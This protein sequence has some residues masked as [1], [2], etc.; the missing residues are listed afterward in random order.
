MSSLYEVKV[1]DL[2]NVADIDIIDVLIKPGDHVTLEQTLAVMET[3]KAT[4]DLPSSAAG[5]VQQVHIK[6]GD[7]VAEG[8]LIVTL[9]VNDQPET[10]NPSVALPAAAAAPASVPPLLMEEAAP[11]AGAK[12]PPPLE[13][14]SLPEAAIIGSS[15]YKPHATPSVRLFARELGVDLSKIQQ[16][17]W[18]QGPR[19]QR[20]YKKPH[21]A[22]A[23][24]SI[25]SI[26][27]RWRHSCYP[28]SGFLSIR[29]N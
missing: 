4:M 7:K 5:T 24:V 29:P 8:T 2:G 11:I 6:I 25:S 14:V 1:P 9:D 16:W 26:W 21:Q 20:R 10:S 27:R 17:K 13:P 28:G 18:P 3:D 15:A 19:T 23:V 12:P 22:H